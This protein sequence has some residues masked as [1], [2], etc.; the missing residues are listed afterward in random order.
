MVPLF[1]LGFRVG[2][3]VKFSE[4]LIESWKLTDY[5][6]VFPLQSIAHGKLELWLEGLDRI[7]QVTPSTMSFDDVVSIGARDD[8]DAHD[9][10]RDAIEA[11]IPWR[12]GPFDLFEHKIDA[13]W[14]S[15]LKWNRVV[16][17]VELQDREVLDIGCGNGYYTY[18]MLQAGARHVVGLEP[19]VPYVLQ[20]ALLRFFSNTPN[21]IVPLRFDAL[22]VQRQFSVVFSMGVLYHQRNPLQHLADIAKVSE[23][24][25]TLILESLYADTDLIPTDRYARMRNVYLVPSIGTLYSMLQEVGFEA[26]EILDTSVTDV[27]EQRRTTLMP[28]DSL[29]EALSTENPSYTIEKHPRPQRIMM[30]AMRT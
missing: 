20:A 7:S 14:R 10:I 25:G 19:F 16:N 1:E 28:F 15:D 3:Q 29:A 22:A 12:K 21:P 13:E 8:T 23:P 6:L 24:G 30:K 17:H 27:R 5:N 9:A 26:I 11:L 4:W 18:R 2:V